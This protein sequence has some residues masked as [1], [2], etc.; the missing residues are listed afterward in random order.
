[1]DID[2]NF[3]RIRSGRTEN[4][5]TGKS[6]PSAVTVELPADKFVC[7]NAFRHIFLHARTFRMI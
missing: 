5:E 4:S 7:A 6:R 1:M 2:Q 3:A